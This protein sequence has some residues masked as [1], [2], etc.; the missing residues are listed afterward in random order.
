MSRGSSSLPDGTELLVLLGIGEVIVA[1]FA[2][3]FVALYPKQG[4]FSGAG[5][6]AGVSR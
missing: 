2:L 4:N 1:L 5:C 6:I 3:V